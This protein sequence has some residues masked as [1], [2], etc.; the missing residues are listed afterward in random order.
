MQTGSV[1]ATE[2]LGEAVVLSGQTTDNGFVHITALHDG[3]TGWLKVADLA[4]PPKP[5]IAN[6]KYVNLLPC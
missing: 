2:L 6:A 3:Y 5:F 4:K 1:L